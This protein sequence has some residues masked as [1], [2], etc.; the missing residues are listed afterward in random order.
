[1][2]Y[3]KTLP[4]IT[5]GLP[6]FGPRGIRGTTQNT[7]LPQL[8]RDIPRPLYDIQPSGRGASARILE[9]ARPAALRVVRALSWVPRDRWLNVVGVALDSLREGA[10][11]RLRGSYSRLLGRG[12]APDNAFREALARELAATAVTRITQAGQTSADPWRIPTQEGLVAVSPTAMGG[13]LD[14]LRDVRTDHVRR[15]AEGALREICA[16]PRVQEAARSVVRETGARIGVPPGTGAR[17]A[18]DGA[19]RVSLGGVGPAADVAPSIADV[20]DV[21]R[22]KARTF[23]DALSVRGVPQEAWLAHAKGA[24]EVLR[25][26]AATRLDAAYSKAIRAGL[27]DDAAIVDAIAREAAATAL[28]TMDAVKQD[29]AQSGVSGIFDDIWDTVSDAACSTVDFAR[30]VTTDIICSEVGGAAAIAISSAAAGA[31]GS[32]A[33]G[34]GTA[35]G[36]AGGAAAGAAAKRAICSS[37]SGGGS[38]CGGGGSRRPMVCPSGSGRLE[39][40]TILGGMGDRQKRLFL[41]RTGNAFRSDGVSGRACWTFARPTPDVGCTGRTEF[42]GPGRVACARGLRCPPGYVIERTNIFHPS[43]KSRLGIQANFARNGIDAGYQKPYFCAKLTVPLDS[44]DAGSVQQGPV[45]LDPRSAAPA[46]S[47]GSP[48]FPPSRSLVG[49]RPTQ[50]GSVG[51][52]LVGGAAL[53]VGAYVISRRT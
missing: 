23:V 48:L 41:E 12:T 44:A 8:S 36:A 31:A 1:M 2:R 39:S 49:A 33:P 7:I 25:R 14:D 40:T 34:A 53:A 47:G 46:Q 3:W 13:I 20:L 10:G 42:G 52:L 16:S 19:R 38:S 4:M 22:A 43:P 37:T 11:T 6:V 45:V 24:F 35:A 27:R 5:P 29:L 32:A 17:I 9:V 30:D 28:T 15:V 21:A 51:L 18:A 50:S 26:G